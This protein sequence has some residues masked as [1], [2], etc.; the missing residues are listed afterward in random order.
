VLGKTASTGKGFSSN[1]KA[2][3]RFQHPISSIISDDILAT[4][5]HHTLNTLK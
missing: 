1:S 2:E 3:A 5:S 4:C